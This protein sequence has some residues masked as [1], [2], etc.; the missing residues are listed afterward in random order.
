MQGRL[1]GLKR[2]RWQLLLPAGIAFQNYIEVLVKKPF[3]VD[4]ITTSSATI[5]F[6]LP[7]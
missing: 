2:Q 4:K 7:F 1:R 6:G 5:I 3:G